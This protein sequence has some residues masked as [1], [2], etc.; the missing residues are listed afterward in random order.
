M[1]QLVKE[2]HAEIQVNLRLNRSLSQVLVKTVFIWLSFFLLLNVQLGIISSLRLLGL[3]QQLTPLLNDADNSKNVV[4]VLN[5][6]RL[7]VA[8]FVCVCAIQIPCEAVDS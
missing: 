3:V 4:R 6:Q 7:A 5:V 8:P 1:K 2:E